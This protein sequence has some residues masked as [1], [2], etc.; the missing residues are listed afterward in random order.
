MQCVF[1]SQFKENNHFELP[2]AGNISC[3][4]GE[5]SSKDCREE[6]RESNSSVSMKIPKVIFFEFHWNL[7]SIYM[8][9]WCNV[10]LLQFV[11]S[12]IVSREQSTGY[13]KPIHCFC[14][15]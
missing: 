5:I 13:V 9:Q 4:G 14:R 1:P 7:Y 3:Q 12:R 11:Q 10:I 6:G 2:C 8:E 15:S